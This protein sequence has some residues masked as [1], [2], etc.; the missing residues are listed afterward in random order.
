MES[1]L[2]KI[3]KKNLEQKPDEKKETYSPIII[4]IDPQNL[5]KVGF[6]MD[7]YL[8]GKKTKKEVI[9]KLKN[10]ISHSGVRPRIGRNECVICFQKLP[11]NDYF[12]DGIVFKKGYMHY[13]EEHDYPI[14]PSFK[15]FIL[16]FD[17]QKQHNTSLN[18]H[19]PSNIKEF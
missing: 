10:I 8:K 15:K 6:H 14:N 17:F 16:E 9:D 12:I 3:F 1:T 18:D 13:L 2:Q 11:I 19:F 5:H 7:P 4:Q